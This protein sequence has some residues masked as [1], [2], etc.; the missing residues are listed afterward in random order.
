MRKPTNR[1]QLLFD[2]KETMWAECLM[3]SKYLKKKKL[4]SGIQI[5]KLGIRECKTMR[6]NSRGTSGSCEPH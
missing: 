1:A 4:Y 5:D 6:A 2:I 3:D